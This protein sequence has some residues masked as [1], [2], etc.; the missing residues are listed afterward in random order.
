LLLTTAV[1]DR[2][3]ERRAG[4]LVWIGS[5]APAVGLRG[6]AVYCA[7]KSFLSG[8]A[9]AAHHEYAARGIRV[10]LLHPALVRT[11]RTAATVDRFAA[12]HGQPV[13]HTADE[14]ASAVV[15]CYLGLTSAAV[16]VAF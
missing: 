4:V 7:T 11:P 5:Q 1:L 13:V 14:V 10:H 15:D 16:E 6:S 2:L 3:W 9:R 8:L 12:S